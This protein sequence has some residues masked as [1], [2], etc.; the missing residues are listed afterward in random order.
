MN[1]RHLSA[2]SLAVVGLLAAGAASAQTRTYN[3][4]DRSPAGACLA[5]TGTLSTTAT[6][7]TTGNVIGCQE[8]GSSGANTL[9]IT[10]W[11]SDGSS[12]TYRTGAVND[13]S[14]NGLG[15]ANQTEYSSGST[16]S[17]QHAADNATPGGADLFLLN[18]TTA[19][20]L[21]SVTLGWTYA[22]GDFQVLR[23]T[24][25]G[26]VSSI[27]GKSAATLLSDGWVLMG[28][29]QDAYGSGTGYDTDQTFSS[30]NSGDLTSSSWI[31]SAFNSNLGG[32]S[33][34]GVDAFKLLGVSSK[35]VGGSSTVSAPG[36]L[37]LAGLGL[38]GAGFLRRRK[39]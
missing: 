20:A 11:S 19:Q 32:S 36:T 18:F 24:G 10:G 9:S 26:A 33:T 35:T 14:G 27:A 25:G 2:L 37:A 38:I 5:T 4:N 17:P 29:V 31:I 8:S 23:W 6:G 34:S 16:G 3:L 28:G 22:D 12:S 30:F 7:S 39:A 1:V 21:K 13:Q 15:M